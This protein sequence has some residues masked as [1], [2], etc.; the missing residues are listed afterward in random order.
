VGPEAPHQ[1]ADDALQSARWSYNAL[2]TDQRSYPCASWRNLCRTGVAA[3][4]QAVPFSGTLSLLLDTGWTVTVPVQDSYAGTTY[5]PSV[6][7]QFPL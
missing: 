4:G 6:G 1:R 7:H 2:H 5:A 3:A